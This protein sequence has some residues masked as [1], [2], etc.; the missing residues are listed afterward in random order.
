M[1]ITALAALLSMLIPSCAARADVMLPASPAQLCQG[2]IAAAERGARLPP[3]LLQAIA[4]VESGRRDP[5]TG[6]VVP[7]PWTL[8]AEGEGHFYASKAEAI[9]AV[10]AFQARG[11]R[12]IDVGCMQVNLMYHPDAFAS[13]DQ[14][15]DPRANAAYAARFLAQLRD[16]T[17]T[18]PKAAAAYHS[19]T[20]E[21]GADYGR[22]VMALWADGARYGARDPDQFQT[23][24]TRFASLTPGALPSLPS[25]RVAVMLPGGSA[26]MRIIPLTDATGGSMSGSVGR[27]L[28][29]YRATPIRLAGRPRG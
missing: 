16:Q 26:P 4:Q 13:L 7:W 15:F 21:I 11:V 14:A 17:G 1:R 12:S 3:K 24:S 18:W 28:D 10:Q 2:A 25:G 19:Q 23:P 8:N 6:A 9:A 27:G 22:R 5:A 20:P 29:A